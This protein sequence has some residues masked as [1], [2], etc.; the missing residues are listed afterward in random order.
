[1]F[2]LLEKEQSTFLFLLPVFT[3][4]ELCYFIAKDVYFRE[5]KTDDDFSCFFSYGSLLAYSIYMKTKKKT[6]IFQ[7]LY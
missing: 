1:M 4:V 5:S 2:F 6:P 3:L 7:C